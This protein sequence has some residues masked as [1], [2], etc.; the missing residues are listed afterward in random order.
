M[1]NSSITPAAPL[2]GRKP[3]TDKTR[4]VSTRRRVPTNWVSGRIRQP[5]IE[6]VLANTSVASGLLV[7]V[8]V[9][10]Q[11]SVHPFSL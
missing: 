7:E 3:P 1:S 2:E 6:P 5:S 4:V 9:S 10:G 11:G 8:Q